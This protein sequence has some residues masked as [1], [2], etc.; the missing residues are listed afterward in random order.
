[1]GGGGRGAWLPWAALPGKGQGLSLFLADLP[2][3]AGSSVQTHTVT[4]IMHT[5]AQGRVGVE[6]PTAEKGAVPRG[7]GGAPSR[8]AA[9]AR[10]PPEG[11]PS[12]VEWRL[13][14]LLSEDASKRGGDDNAQ[15]HTADDDHDLLLQG[16]QGGKEERPQTGQEAAGWGRARRGGAHKQRGP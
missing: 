8:K 6:G 4:E 16:R 11:R 12:R 15:D 14:W 7:K 3:P 1:M 13:G 10:G 9:A 5:T 2:H